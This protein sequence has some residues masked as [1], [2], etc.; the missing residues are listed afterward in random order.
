MRAFRAAKNI[1]VAE[2]GIEGIFTQENPPNAAHAAHGQLNVAF[3]VTN[4]YCSQSCVSYKEY[5]IDYRR[6][7]RSGET[8]TARRGSP[9]LKADIDLISCGRGGVPFICFAL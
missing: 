5:T 9:A 3:G 2:A 6:L 8:Y 4:E 1:L 7:L